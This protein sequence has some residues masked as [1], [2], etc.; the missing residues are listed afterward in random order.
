MFGLIDLLLQQVVLGL[1]AGQQH[2]L[3]VFGRLKCHIFCLRLLL[4]LALDVDQ[5]LKARD[6]LSLLSVHEPLLVELRC[7]LL[8]MLIVLLGGELIVCEL[9][10]KVLSSGCDRIVKCLSNTLIVLEY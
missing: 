1:H 7:K 5:L 6:L 10:Q 2:L 9:A 4:L 8:L 3:L